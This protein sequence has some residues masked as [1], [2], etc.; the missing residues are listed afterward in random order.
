MGRR[1]LKPIGRAL[2][3]TLL[4]T[5]LAAAWL[6]DR[7]GWPDLVAGEA[8]T[9]MQAESLAR[10]FD[11]A[12]T[13][14]DFDRLLLRWH[15][16]PR[17]LELASG[18]G[19]GRLAFDR[20]FPYALY[21][22]PFVAWRPENGFAIANALLLAAVSLFAARTLERRGVVSAPL[23][24][25]VLV[26]AS[27]LFAYT[28]LAT[29]DLF[30]FA[31]T[32]AAFCLLAPAGA[33]GPR[34]AASATAG[35]GVA[36]GALLAIPC[37]GEPLNAVLLAAAFFVPATGHR[38]V[39]RALAAG[40]AAM[41][42]AIAAVQ[43]L[44]GGGL[45][46]FA[47]TRCRFTPETGYPLVDF[48]AAEWPQTLHRLAALQE[49]G[50]GFAW[51]I[52]LWLWNL[53]YLFLGRT[54]GLVPYF[55]PLLLLAIG[56]WRGLRRDG[57]WAIIAAAVLWGL[58]VVVARPFDLHGGEG[59][60]NRLFLPVYGA[61]WLIAGRAAGGSGDRQS[62]HGSRPQWLLLATLATT[63]GVAALFLGELWADPW[64]H[65]TA[66]GRG[67]RHP[68]ELA[69]RLLPYETTQRWLPGLRP[70]GGRWAEHG[71][72]AVKPLTGSTWAEAR[73]R[74]LVVAGGSGH[75]GPAELLI[76]S[77]RPLAAIRLAIEE[78]GVEPAV[79][80]GG[81][82][83]RRSDSPEA[84]LRFVP[85]GLRRRHPLAGSRVRREAGPRYLYLLSFELPPASSGPMGFE[86]VG[87]PLNDRGPAP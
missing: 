35:R 29:G 48:T 80:R 15:G 32:V 61:L 36:A 57:R 72:L 10:D 5:L 40:A 49:G 70:P 6:Y 37:A 44:A 54:I 74:R 2:L 68:T 20:P 60:A 58:A 45:Y 28:F 81:K 34:A 50:P 8:T 39:R 47:T 82:M 42:A 77:R 22:A 59:V 53:L 67:S 27:V 56:G 43:W 13:R 17:D 63:L 51:G 24:V 33:G 30:L 26:F 21:L 14:A 31:V 73:S 62:I 66:G 25:A 52:D 84:A 7:A 11:L 75:P 71:G 85:Q 55:A 83:G 12:Y 69:R 23:L 19:G 4:A 1:Y 65:P 41:L 3:A 78:E 38:A 16:D 9:L 18:D 87:E 86:L 79:I 46:F 76:A 64:T